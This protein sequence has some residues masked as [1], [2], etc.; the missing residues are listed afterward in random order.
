M[1]AAKEFKEFILRGN[2]VDLAVG[3]VIGAAFGGVIKAFVADIIT[4][5]VGLPGKIDLSNLHGHIGNADFAI[6]DFLNTL[7]AFIL[8]AAVVFFLI[9]KPVNH[10]QSLQ[11][12]AEEPE[13]AP[14]LTREEV[15]LSEIRDALVSRSNPAA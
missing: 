5:L 4:P 3:V 2:V 7:I 1:S 8:V 13:A 14:E 15:L 12:K 9:V 6:G 11:K 10:L